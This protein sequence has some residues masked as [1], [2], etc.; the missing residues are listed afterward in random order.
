V[1]LE[2]LSQRKMPITPSGIEP[3]TFRLVAQCLSQPVRWAVPWLRRLVAGVPPRRP[4][5][6]PGV[7]PCGI[8]GEQSGTGT[9]VSPSTSV[10]H[11]QYHSTGAPLLGKGQKDNL[12]CVVHNFDHPVSSIHGTL[13]ALTSPR[14]RDAICVCA[15]NQG[16]TKSTHPTC[17]E[18]SC[19]AV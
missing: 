7:S 15:H 4:G 17:Q 10:F 1:R 2:G 5:F 6:D 19:A 9:G 16:Q 3:A 13:N 11:C 8:C 12:H 18:I 14:C